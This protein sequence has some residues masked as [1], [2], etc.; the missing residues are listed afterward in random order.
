MD[1]AFQFIIAHDGICSEA[2]YPYVGAN[3]P[4]QANCTSA[5]IIRQFVEV[6]PHDENA[7]QVAVAQQPVSIA[8]E[9]DQS[10]FQFYAGGVLDDAT[11]GVNLDHGVLI[12]GY[13]HDDT[14]HKDF[15]TIKNSWGP[16]W[17]DHGY[18]HIVRNVDGN[19]ARQCGLTSV[20]SYPV[21]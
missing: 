10:V 12:V 11:C 15:W 21:V 6:T 20:P 7:L 8:L 5:A 19:D 13:G 14:V 3:N 18:I 1:Q 16:S 9:A 17:G 2:D 4:C